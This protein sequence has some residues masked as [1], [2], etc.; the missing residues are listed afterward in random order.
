MCWSRIPCLF[1][2]LQKSK[3]QWSRNLH[4]LE[5]CKSNMS[6]KSFHDVL[7]RWIRNL[8]IFPYTSISWVWIVSWNAGFLMNHSQC[9]NSFKTLIWDALWIPFELLVQFINV[10]EPK[11]E[12]AGKLWPL[13]HTSMIFSLI[14]MHAIAIGIFTLKKLPEATTFIVPLPILTLL[15][16]EYC[17][18]RFLP[19]FTA[20]SVEVCSLM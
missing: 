8:S 10:Y 1:S 3:T 13:V 6:L 2:Y 5:G 15:F 19:N 9:P 18:K 12:T 17:R 4:N 7:L 20:Y 14:L 16:N 11:Y